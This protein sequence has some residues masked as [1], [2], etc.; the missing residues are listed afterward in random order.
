MFLKKKLSKTAKNTIVKNYGRLKGGA[1]ARPPPLNTPLDGRLHNGWS[2]QCGTGDSSLK[3]HA[4][5]TIPTGPQIVAYFC[6]WEWFTSG[7]NNLDDQ[8]VPASS[9]NSFKINLPRRQSASLFISSWIWTSLPSRDRFLWERWVPKA[10][11][12]RCGGGEGFCPS[13][14]TISDFGS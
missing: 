1:G 2:L 3:L 4:E 13:P 5:E 6:H 10:Q 9:S 8:S 12:S 11:G 14:E 7:T